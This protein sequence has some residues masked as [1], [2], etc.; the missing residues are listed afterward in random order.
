MKLSELAGLDQSGISKI[1]SGVRVNPNFTSVCAI[2]SALGVTPN[3]FMAV[4]ESN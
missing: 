2:A 1:E 4:V 3:Y